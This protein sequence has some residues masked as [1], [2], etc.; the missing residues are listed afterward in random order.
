[1]K[2]NDQIK[3][4]FSFRFAN[5]VHVR[6]VSLAACGYFKFRVAFNSNNT[7]AICDAMHIRLDHMIVVSAVYGTAKGV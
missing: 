5:D 7:Y 6:G 1:M 2:S 4:I 3:S